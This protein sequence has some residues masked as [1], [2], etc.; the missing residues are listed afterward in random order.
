MANGGR[1][2]RG[3]K[4]GGGRDL[5]AAEEGFM[6]VDCEGVEKGKGTGC[7]TSLIKTAYQEGREERETS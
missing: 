2:W 6:T 1:G 3:G 7:G 4:L 5:T